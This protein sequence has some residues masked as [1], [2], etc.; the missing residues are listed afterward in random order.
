MCQSILDMRRPQINEYLQRKT[1]IPVLYIT[2]AL[3]L[4]AGMSHKVLGINQLFVSAQEK[5]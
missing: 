3:G 4:A 5:F 1:D 2:Q